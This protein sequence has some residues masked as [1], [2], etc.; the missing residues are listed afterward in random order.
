M[1]AAFTD[2]AD[3]DEIQ[4]YDGK[5]Q[6]DRY[7]IKIINP[8]QF[9]LTIEYLTVDVTFRQFKSIIRA[10]KEQAGLASIGSTNKATVCQYTRFV[11]ALRL[12]IFWRCS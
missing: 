3:A 9:N 8:I 10:T 2:I 1:L 7:G 11:C 6:T 4:E 12:K 5:L